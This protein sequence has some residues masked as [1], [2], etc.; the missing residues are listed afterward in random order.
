MR[1]EKATQT[2]KQKRNKNKNQKQNKNKKRMGEK[3]GQKEN[4]TLDVL[5]AAWS[6]ANDKHK[7]NAI[8]VEGIFGNDGSRNH[9]PYSIQF[10][11]LHCFLQPAS[12][13]RHVLQILFPHH[14]A[15]HAS[16]I[17]TQFIT[18]YQT[19]TIIIIND[20]INLQCAQRRFQ[21]LQKQIIII[22]VILLLL[23][24]KSQSKHATLPVLLILFTCIR[25]QPFNEPVRRQ[26]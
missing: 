7:H 19:I 2:N 6:L 18:I 15:N 8:V 3:K 5:L 14:D 22:I 9:P 16:W 23:I 12:V 4:E 25:H 1:E 11:V 21:P 24:I 26:I 17:H 13:L 20:I 10:H